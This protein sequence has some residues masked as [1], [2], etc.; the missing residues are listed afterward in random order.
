[1]PDLTLGDYL[2]QFTD[3]LD[4]EDGN[5]IKEFVTT[6][7]KSYAFLTDT[8]VQHCT[9]KGI[10]YNNLVSHKLNFEQIKKIVYNQ[11][12]VISVPQYKFCRKKM[13]WIVY[14]EVQEKKF[15]FTYDKR[16]VNPDLTTRPFGFKKL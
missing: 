7:P 11:E 5:Y 8:G 12:E 15:R 3:E 1:M 13:K 2:G 16:I 6:G 9:L 4:K 14:T 10:T